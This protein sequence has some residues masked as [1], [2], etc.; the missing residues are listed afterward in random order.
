MRLSA[1][2]LGG[3]IC[4]GVAGTAT[5]DLQVKMQRVD[6]KGAGDDVGTVTISE[7]QYGLVF[8]PE[9]SKLPSGVH[10]FH[11]HEKADCGPK[12]TDGKMVPAGAAGGH[13]DPGKAG[14]HGAPWGDGHLGDL[15][16]LYVDADGNA[17][18]PVLAPRMKSLKDVSGR[19]LMIHAGGDNYSDHP[20]KLGGGGG[21]VACGTVAQ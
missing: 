20:E 18:T 8:T 10:G 6:A 9:L 19:A 7:S 12:E 3:M 1:L 11:V 13:L 15:P 17:R 5:A 2:W 14:R 16:A 4:M 21:R